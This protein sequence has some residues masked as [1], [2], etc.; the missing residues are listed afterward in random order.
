MAKVII[1]AF[2]KLGEF[3]LLHAKLELA[4]ERTYSLE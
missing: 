3:L 4:D 2:E 1:E